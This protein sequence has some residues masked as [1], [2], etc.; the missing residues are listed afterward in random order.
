M[1][2]VFCNVSVSLK[3]PL[4]WVLEHRIKDLL[5]ATALCDWSCTSNQGCSN[6]TKVFKFSSWT[7]KFAEDLE[8]LSNS[9]FWNLSWS[10]VLNTTYIREVFRCIIG[11]FYEAVFST[12]S[13]KAHEESKTSC[14]VQTYE[15]NWWSSWTSKFA[16]DLVN[17]QSR[18]WNI[19]WSGPLEWSWGL[20]PLTLK[21]RISFSTSSQ[22]WLHWKGSK[23]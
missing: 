10:E 7:S 20:G 17:G 2:G 21:A 8:P 5:H 11:G 3:V 19:S 15:F 13:S 22:S 9:S 16:D 1:K 12:T 18:F 14:A 4:T 23:E 6:K